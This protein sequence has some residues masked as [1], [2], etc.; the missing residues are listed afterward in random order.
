VSCLTFSQLKPIVGAV[1]IYW[2]YLSR[3]KTVVFPD[4]SRPIMAQWRDPTLGKWSV[5]F[6]KASLAT[7]APILQNL[8]LSPNLWI[9]TMQHSN[10]LL[11]HC[12]V[13]FSSVL[14]KL[15][16]LCNQTTRARLAQLYSVI[17]GF[18]MAGPGRHHRVAPP[19]PNWR[20]NIFLT[21]ARH[22]VLLNFSATSDRASVNFWK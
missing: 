7:L 12:C 11:P 13:C 20:Q 3:Y 17:N 5:M 15:R 19:P 16:S 6:D 4:E 18:K 1:F 14:T 2:L 10:F 9:S 22:A 8:A 21:L